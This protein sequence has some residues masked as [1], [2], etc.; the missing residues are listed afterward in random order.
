MKKVTMQFGRASGAL[1][2]GGATATIRGEATVS[3]ETDATLH[4]VDGVLGVNTAAVVE[5]NNTLPITSAAVYT[6]VGNIN[7][8]LSTI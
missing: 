2:T 1:N 6:E 8:L 4:F 3:F 7:A 5:E